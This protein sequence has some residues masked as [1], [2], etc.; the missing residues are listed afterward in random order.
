MFYHKLSFYST[1]FL[2]GPITQAKKF[3]DFSNIP[4]AVIRIIA[5]ITVIA[6][7]ILAIV[8]AVLVSY[9]LLLLI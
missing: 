3:V 6:A 9:L 4:E 1:V 2:V 8:C 7:V 5:A